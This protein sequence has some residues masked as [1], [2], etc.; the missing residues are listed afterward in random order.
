M[1]NV[2]IAAA[3]LVLGWFAL[4]DWAFGL[5][6]GRSEMVPE[7]PDYFNE[8]VWLERPASQPSGGWE[9][10][11]GVD[12]FL[13]SSP[14]TSAVRKGALPA[15]DDA[16]KKE[17]EALIVQTGLRTDGLTVYAPAYRSPSPASDKRERDEEIKLAQSDIALSMKRYLSAENRQRGL[18]IVAAPKTEPM[19]YAA[20]QQ[21]PETAQFRQRFGGVLLPSGK[22]KSRWDTVMRGCSPAFDDCSLPTTM[23][24]NPMGMG[25]V[26][27]RLPQPHLTY[28]ADPALSSQISD[29]VE[30]LSSWLDQNAEKPAEP[31]NSWAA[32]EVVDVAPIHR[33]NSDQDISGERGD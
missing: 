30:A 11:W 1:R 9:A 29:R 17:Y 33:P 13:I 12:V 7:T 15:E 23:D 21:L 3:L 6:L 31:F 4:K 25:W 24:A 26:M 2:L 10:P 20:L 19:L 18:V 16:L 27:P 28:S 8:S 22:N 14:V 5:V 32:D